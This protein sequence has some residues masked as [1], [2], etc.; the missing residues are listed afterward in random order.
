MTFLRCATEITGPHK[1]CK[2]LKPFQFHE[3]TAAGRQGTPAHLF[4][5]RN[6]LSPGLFRFIARALFAPVSWP[7]DHPDMTI[8]ANA[9]KA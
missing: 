2:I 4:L 9:K 5:V 3:D 6:N 7:R 1:G 8:T